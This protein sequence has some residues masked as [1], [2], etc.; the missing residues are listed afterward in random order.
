[1]PICVEEC[2]QDS[3][4]LV[5]CPKAASVSED[6]S[7]EQ[8][9]V[10]V[11]TTIVQEVVGQATYPTVVVG[12]R[13]CFPDAGGQ[14]GS[15]GELLEELHGYIR[16]W[17]D[18]SWALRLLYK[19]GNLASDV[20][21]NFLLLG[22]ICA[23][24]FVLSF[25]YLLLLRFVAKLLVYVMLGVLPLGFGL[26]GAA[27]IST[28]H[29]LTGHQALSPM[30]ES[31]PDPF[32]AMVI[33]DA[34]G[35]TCLLLATI[36]IC[37]CCL[38]DTV[39]MVCG[40]I[41]ASVE[42]MFDMPTLLIEPVLGAALKLSV[43]SVLL[44]GLAYLLSLG[45]VQGG[46]VSLGGTTLY[47]LN[48]TFT[49]TAD[50]QYRLLFYMFGMF[51]IMEVCDACQ[52]FTISYAV[53]L[54]YYKP[55]P[56]RRPHFPVVRGFLNAIC[57]HL[58]TLALGALLVATTQVLRLVLGF[59]KRQ[60]EASCSPT[61][62]CLAS[63]CTGCLACFQKC[64]E[65]INKSAYVDVAI[66]SSNFLH[67]AL[68]VFKFVTQEVPAIALLSGTCWIAQVG[69][70]LSISLAS[71]FGVYLLVTR[72]DPW[73]NVSSEQH[74]SEPVLLAILSGMFGVC[75]S[76]VFMWVFDQCSDTLLYVFADNR[77]RSPETVSTY[78][79]KTLSNLVD[80][81]EPEEES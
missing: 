54:W 30:F 6:V 37:I 8:P 52:Q 2:P 25:A 13:L 50:Q 55:K 60:T 48:R 42:C 72:V 70:V 7:G 69:G 53:V 23:G 41:K 21:N 18:A 32:W 11:I 1:M 24:A 29:G 26:L 27:L 64:L 59:V 81:F 65:F 20:P 46:E 28:A 44:L 68:H 17:I 51:W 56:K 34:L 67:A 39:A 61:G 36:S 4:A 9:G 49:Y 14:E 43:L 58:G 38:R 15:A 80:K 3:A 10:T 66:R 79:P 5:Y 62:A 31:V 45:T 35:V 71:G 22:G 47:G 40:C 63:C 16:G 76:T 74:V 78:A 12:G 33:S 73:V 19:A 77:K 75:V 57:F